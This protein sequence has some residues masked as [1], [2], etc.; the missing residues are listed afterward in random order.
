MAARWIESY[1][2]GGYIRAAAVE[3]VS[4]SGV[5]DGTTVISGEPGVMLPRGVSSLWTSDQ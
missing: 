2:G 1:H 3:Q 5:S 4:K